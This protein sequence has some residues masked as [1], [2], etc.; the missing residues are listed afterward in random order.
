MGVWSF[1][2]LF[3]RIAGP[4]CLVALF[5][6]GCTSDPGEIAVVP[7]ASVAPT[8]QAVSEPTSM[9]DPDTVAPTETPRPTV[10]STPTV[11]APEPSSPLRIVFQST[12]AASP[13]IY[14]MDE[15]GSNV[16]LLLPEG[17]E[18][19]WSP[20]SD[21]VLFT[22]DDGNIWILDIETSRLFAFTVDEGDDLLGTWSPDGARIAFVS[23]RDGDSD[24]YVAAAD[25]SDVTQITNDPALD[26]DPAWSPDGT[27]IAFGS[28]RDQLLGLY[29][30]NA[31][32]SDVRLLRETDDPESRPAWSPDGSLILFQDYPGPNLFVIATDGT[33]L[34]AL[35]DNEY[36]D[37]EAEWSPDGSRIVFNSDRTG[38]NEIWIMDADGTD[39]FPGH[40]QPRPRRL[41]CRLV[42][43]SS[44]CRSATLSDVSPNRRYGALVW[45][46][47]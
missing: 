37:G 18:P 35:T 21:R 26:I 6:A 2:G 29:I 47:D 36:D 45:A 42:N 9:P 38:N 46:G 19:V 8:P 16:T 28:D 32:G 11:T 12:R 20:N 5:V 44:K 31:D 41:F 30:M 4:I 25:G 7:S 3:A 33:G 40:R 43:A 23:S 24:I 14:V 10:P 34:M 13:G 17:N 1:E 15:D 39:A 27:Q 22:G